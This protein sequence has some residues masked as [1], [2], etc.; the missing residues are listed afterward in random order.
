M[1]QLGALA[2]S[3]NRLSAS[4]GLLT[5]TVDMPLGKAIS[6]VQWM[7]A[8]QGCAIQISLDSRR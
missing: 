7:K 5:Q 3:H 6:A 4:R 2:C 8:I 1:T